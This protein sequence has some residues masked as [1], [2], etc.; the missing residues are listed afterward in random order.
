MG[1]TRYHPPMD[2]GMRTSYPDAN[3]I[4]PVMIEALRETLGPKLVGLAV[5]GS[6]VTGAYEPGISDVDFVAA[7][8]DDLNEAEG[9]RVA[10]MHAGIVAA[11]PV[12]TERIE[13]GYF[14]LATLRAFA[15]GSPMGRISPGEP[16]HLTTAD[17][18]WLFNVSMLRE[19]G[20]RIWGP[21]PADLVGPIPAER[22]RAALGERMAEW[23]SWLDEAPDLHDL[24][25]QGYMVLTMCRARALAVTG[26][27]LGKLEAA[28][29]AQREM[30][31]W[32]PLIAKAIGWRRSVALG[33]PVS[34]DPAETLL[35]VLNFVRSS[36]EAVLGEANCIRGIR[37]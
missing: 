17:T 34:V 10:Q 4:F 1:A 5:F 33:E 18:G 16:F 20:I 9:T 25:A 35:R 8:T 29:W 30:P 19:R 23:R 2:D 6:L 26:K 36:I 28:A 37:R 22:M 15:P 3:A 21:P 11:Y 7:L 27:N 31:E 13:V 24:G 32:A 12:W 14:S